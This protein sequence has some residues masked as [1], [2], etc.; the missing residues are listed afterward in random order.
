MSA[1]ENAAASVPSGGGARHRLDG[2]ALRARRWRKRVGAGLAHA[3]HRTAAQVERGL[4][5]EQAAFSRYADLVRHDVRARESMWAYRE[6]RALVRRGSADLARYRPDQQVPEGLVLF[7]GP[8][9]SGHSLVGSLLDAHPE[10]VIAHELFA[11]RHLQQ[12]I[13][14]GDVADAIKLNSAIYS[15]LGRG[16]T[17]YNYAVPGQ[18]QGRATRLRLIGD[19][20]GNPTAALLCRHPEL[21]GRLER[22]R[23]VHLVHVLRNPYDNIA[24]MA[25]R[26]HTSLEHAAELYFATMQN[27]AEVQRRAGE[28]IIDVY[29]DDLT[30]EPKA[31]LRRLLQALGIEE[32]G[33]DYLEACAS[34]VFGRPNRRPAR[35]WTPELT[36]R[37][38]AGLADYPFLARFRGTAPAAGDT[39]APT[40]SPAAA[41]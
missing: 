13:A 22:K 6:L 33:E 23:P 1:P 19:K 29:L 25:Q 16:A 7:V 18:Y 27:V 37:I 35:D 8:A 2:V 3:Y 20:K 5:R 14:F 41:G 39:A 9:R 15:E 10:I 24:A 17:G 21:L 28:R 36:R 11:L 12:G 34:I 38:E 32:A 40:A 26:E 30:A 31:V 4:G